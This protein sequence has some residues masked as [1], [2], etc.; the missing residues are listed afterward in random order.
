MLEQV[1][2]YRDNN[3]FPEEVSMEQV[4]QEDMLF[5]RHR[6][7][8][9]AEELT[10]EFTKDP[11]LLHQYY[12]LRS[13]V[14]ARTHGVDFE[15][16][17]DSFDTKSDTLIVRA[18]NQVLGGVRMT[19]SH[20]DKPTQ[21]SMEKY[22]VKLQENLPELELA[23]NGYCE[24]SRMAILEE[25]QTNDITTAFI[26][27]MFQHCHS[28]GI[29]YAFSMS[30]NSLHRLYRITSRKLDYICRVVDN[31]HFPHN[32]DGIEGNGFK[33]LLFDVETSLTKNPKRN[34]THRTL[35]SL[36]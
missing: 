11:A 20:P 6:K 10:Y 13:L 28:L 7:L 18:G 30:P 31:I 9:E 25:Y 34:L 33:L 2:Q 12:V 19:F 24:A 15:K 17:E 32:I 1:R 21:L 16:E 5:R 26:R 27:L 22:G 8:R 35:V 36:A 14:F 4:L 3:E 29:K 23:K